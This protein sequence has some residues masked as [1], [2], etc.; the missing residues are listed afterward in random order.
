MVYSG[1]PSTSHPV[2]ISW[3][4]SHAWKQAFYPGVSWNHPSGPRKARCVI[5]LLLTP[6]LSQQVKE[7]RGG[8]S[9]FS[10]HDL[11]FVYF[12]FW[13]TRNNICHF[14]SEHCKS[15]PDCTTCCQLDHWSKR[16]CLV[17]VWLPAVFRQQSPVVL[18]ITHSDSTSDAIQA[19]LSELQSHCYHC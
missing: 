17:P 15:F 2:V 7:M 14:L 13:E 6:V 16:L 19:D 10:P 8:P 1:P 9:S 12:V 5:Y 4:F 11:Y 3:L 18:S